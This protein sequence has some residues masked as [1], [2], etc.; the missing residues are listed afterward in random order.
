VVT[1]LNAFLFHH[2]EHYFTTVKA[3]VNQT[4]PGLLY[5][6]T[7][8]IG[9][10]SAPPR[11][12]ILQAAGASCDVITMQQV[13]GD[14]PTCTDLQQRVDFIAQNGG[15]KPWIRWSGFVANPDSYESPWRSQLNWLQTQA[16]RGDYYQNTMLPQ[17]FNSCDT[18]TGSCHVVGS[19]WWAWVDSRPE[20]LNWGLVTS[21][22][23]PYDG[24]SA[25]PT[26]GYDAWGYPTGCLTGFG[27][28]QASYGDFITYVRKGNLWVL[29]QL[30]GTLPPTTTINLTTAP[31]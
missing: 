29:D 1:D 19:Q 4:L 24:V 28:E 26:Q 13:P 6:G 20:K 8:G 16:A 23:D 15:D 21:R 3:K 25:T 12:E 11:K 5:L 2:A 18:P 31:H 22:D 14:C 7:A 27:C 30:A 9:S 10:W 17:S